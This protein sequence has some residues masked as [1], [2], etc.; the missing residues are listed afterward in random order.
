[1]VRISR[2]RQ[3]ADQITFWKNRYARKAAPGWVV[4]G[5]PESTVMDWRPVY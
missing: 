5:A 4:T 2:K 3:A 1:M